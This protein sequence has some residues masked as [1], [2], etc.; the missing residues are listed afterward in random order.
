MCL[1]GTNSCETRRNRKLCLQLCELT[2]FHIQF[3]YIQFTMASNKSNSEF[4][5][6]I[7][8]S[9]HVSHRGKAKHMHFSFWKHPSLLWFVFLIW[10][11]CSQNA[12]ILEIHAHTHV[13]THTCMYIYIDTYMHTYTCTHVYICTYI[14]VFTHIHAYTVASSFASFYLLFPQISTI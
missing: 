7:S 2:Q 5:G 13:C 8:F 3:T 12:L 10:E 1:F 4:L 11:F 14:H 9:Q 6:K